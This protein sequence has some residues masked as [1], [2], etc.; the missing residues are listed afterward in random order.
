MLNMEL[1]V[2]IFETLIVKLPAI[3][4]DDGIWEP[5]LTDYQLLEETPDLLSVICASGLAPPI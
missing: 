4:N 1:G 3:I 5:I 2:K